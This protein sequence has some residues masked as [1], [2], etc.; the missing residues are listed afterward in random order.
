[1]IQAEIV[2]SKLILHTLLVELNLFFIEF[3]DKFVEP[4]ILENIDD[5]VPLSLVRFRVNI[6]HFDVNGGFFG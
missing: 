6:L 5:V 4:F 1:M 2:E 3:F